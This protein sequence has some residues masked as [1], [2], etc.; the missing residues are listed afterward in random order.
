LG[1]I[2]INKK[3]ADTGKK[4]NRGGMEDRLKLKQAVSKLKFL[5]GKRRG[6]E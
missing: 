1:S 2:E 3:R 6:G 4:G 5:G